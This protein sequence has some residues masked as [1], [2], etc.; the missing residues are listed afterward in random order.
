MFFWFL[1][2]SWVLVWAVLHDPSVDYRLVMVGALIPDIV[3]APFGGLRLGH[4][5]AVSVAV[6]LVVMVA[7]RGRRRSR[8]RLLALP[9]GMLVHLVLDGV[10]MDTR[11]FW[12]PFGGWS[13]AGAGGLPS[14]SHPLALTIVEEVA[15][16]GCLAWCWVRFRLTEPARRSAFLHTGRVGADMG[17]R[18]GTA[19]IPSPR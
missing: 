11:V 15:G 9:I 14:L 5:L 12:W 19:G 7:T 17:P 4:T 8:R 6:L 18:G 1:G 16:V 3:D 13:L 2:G 10:W